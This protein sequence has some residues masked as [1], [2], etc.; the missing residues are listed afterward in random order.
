MQRFELH[1]YMEAG[2][3]QVEEGPCLVFGI[4]LHGFTDGRMCDG[5]P[6]FRGGKCSAYKK[7]TRR[8]AQK[9]LDTAPVETVS[10][11]AARL[12]VS[13]SEVRRR[14]RG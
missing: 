10:E 13:I 8:L 12:G 5:C 6:E 4:G 14:R 1:E 2:C 11:Q 3:M 9:T 7:L